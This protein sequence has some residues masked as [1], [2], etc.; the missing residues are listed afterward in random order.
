MHPLKQLRKLV[1]N[2]ST[3]YGRLVYMDQ[4]GY[5]LATTK[6]SISVTKA[7]ND[8]TPYKVGDEVKFVNGQL[9]GRKIRE[10]TVYVV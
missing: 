7:S 9:M 1:S 4:T 10:P 8:A 3:M 6:G 2:N 5:I